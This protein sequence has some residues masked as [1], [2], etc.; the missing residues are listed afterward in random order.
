MHSLCLY[1]CLCVG[2][3]CL[4]VLFCFLERSSEDYILKSL[5][6]SLEFSLVYMKE[7]PENMSLRNL[8]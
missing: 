2:G 1:V 3:G 4:G 7:F 6:A 8:Q 5:C